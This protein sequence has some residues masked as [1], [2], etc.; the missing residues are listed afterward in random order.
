MKTKMKNKLLVSLL[1]VSVGAVSLSF[2]LANLN[3]A[4][5]EGNKLTMELTNAASIRYDAPTGIR[6]ETTYSATDFSAYQNYEFGTLVIP[7]D[8]LDG[9]LTHE[10]ENVQ[11]IRKL[12]WYEGKNG[13]TENKKVMRSVLTEI[14]ES[15]YGRELTA[16]SYYFDGT[17]YVYSDITV[18]RSVARTASLLL[19]QGKTDNHEDD[20]NRY[21]DA[22]SE[23]LT[24]SVENGTTFEMV[25]GGKETITATPIT[26][27]NSGGYGV[28]WSSTDTKV[29]TVSN[30]VITAVGNGETVVTVA[31]GTEFSY[32][33][34]VK[35]MDYIQRDGSEI[36]YTTENPSVGNYGLTTETVGGRTGVYKYSSTAKEWTDKLNIKVGGHLNSADGPA[37]TRALREFKNKGYN[38]VVFDAYMTK[39]SYLMVSSLINA[40]DYSNGSGTSVGVAFTAG[41]TFTNNN[42]NL[43]VY[44][45]GEEVSAISV[46]TWYTFVV[47]YSQIN[48]DVFGAKAGVYSRIELGGIMGT[49][50]FDNVRYYGNTTW[51]E[52]IIPEKNYLQYDGSEFVK[53]APWSDSTGSYG[54]YDG[55]VQGRTGVYKYSSTL[56]NWNDKISIKQTNHLGTAVYGSNNAVKN[57]MVGNNYAYVTFDLCMESGAIVINVPDIATNS[58]TSTQ[59]TDR[60]WVGSE[61]TKAS[62]NIKYYSVDANGVYT[63]VTKLMKN[64]W[65]TVVVK[66]DW[67]VT[68]TGTAYAG[69]DI[70]S[71]NEANVYFDNVRY[72]NANPFA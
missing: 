26:T 49:V 7:S 15:F 67:E 27:K 16:C 62:N 53:A 2:A 1:C 63:E 40:D 42:G 29:A 58:T 32:S 43:K 64:Q 13:S 19:S 24:A 56:K 25:V 4:S 37:K 68:Y 54:L 22:V 9:D 48:P 55:M 66:Y 61:I 36:V 11:D 39:G 71:W 69:I 3:V 65:Y 59:K 34:T 17:D 14:P 18:E 35:V 12:V 72:Y 10:T 45:L 31:F 41:T 38:Y 8:L 70:G 47:D 28:V 21:V 33:Y 51:Q 50:Y 30:G 6:F 60:V 57:N 44:N 20:L 23:G 52:D 5:A 46:D